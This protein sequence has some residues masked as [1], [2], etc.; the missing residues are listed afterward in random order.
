[1]KKLVQSLFVLLFVA[2]AALAQERTVSGTITA[3]EDGLPLPGVSVT[4]KGGLAGTQTDVNGRYS[5]SVPSG[6]KFLAF[7]FIGFLTKEAAIPANN[8][9]SLSLANDTKQ[10]GEVVVVGA[11]GIPRE[12]KSL[13]YSVSRVKAEAL[14]QKSEPDLLK[15]LQ[16]KVAGVDIRSSQGTPGAATRIQIRGNSSFFG[17]NQPLIVVD[18]VPYSND[19]ITTSSQVSGGGAYSSGIGNLDPNDIASFQ[20]LKGSAAG[21]LYGSRASNGVI[22]ITT[23]SGNGGSK[24]Q[25]VQVNYRSS[26]SVENVSNL[27]DYQNTYGAGAN[28]VYQNSNGTWGPSFSSRDSIP[29]W[30]GYLAKY[31]KLFPSSGNIAYRAVPNNV[32]DLFKTGKVYENS[33]SL[34]GGGESSSI[35][36][37]ASNLDQ[38][39]YVDNSGYKRNSISAG[40]NTSTKF[41]LNLHGNV[42]YSK[43]NQTGGVFGENQVSGAASQFARTLF[44]ARN[45]DI[46]GL[47]YEDNITPNGGGQFDNPIW[48]AYHNTINTLE[49][50]FVTN[51]SADMKVYKWIN[52]TFRI[53]S[54]VQRLNRD[55]IT[56]IGSRAAEGLGR[57]VNANY[58]KQEIESTFL[59]SFNPKISSDFDLTGTLGANNNRRSTSNI[60]NSGNIFKTPNIFRLSNTTQQVFGDNISDRRLYGVLGEATLGYKGYAYVT[61][62]GRN[63]WSSTLPVNNR[64]YFY[65]SVSGSLIFSQ[66]LKLS[67]KVL[68]YGKV[69]AGYAKVGRD[70]DPYSLSNVFILNQPFLSQNTATVSTDANNPELKPEFTK[71]LEIGT[72]LSFFKGRIKTDIAY[73]DKKSS[74]LIAP[75]ATPPSS[76][77]SRYYTNYGGITNKGVEVELS[78]IP[79]RTKN[80]SWEATA[81]FTKNRNTVTSLVEG[82]QRIAI[83]SGLTSIQQFAE[84][85]MPF[86]YLRGTLSSRDATGNLLIDPSTGQL[87]EATESGFVGDPNPDFKAGL[88]NTFKY[89]RFFLNAGFDW[90]QGGSL[91]SVT[92]SSLLGR[93][94]TT[95]TEDRDKTWVI[96]GVYGDPNSKQ[97]VLDGNGKTIPNSVRVTTNDLYFGQTFAIN[98]SSEWNTYDATVYRLRELTLGYQ[99]PKSVFNKFPISNM[100]ISLT[101][102]NLFYYAP[103]FPK[104]SNF[105]PDVN[106]FGSTNTQGIELSAAPSTRRFGVNLSVTF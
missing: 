18:G 37:T 51:L 47:P 85:G 68:D 96:P 20:V 49:E 5:I 52:A 8:K 41:G 21:A 45:W 10:L 104:G 75:I 73:Y 71:E 100:T 16:G 1:M 88:T 3:L 76:G 27:P 24:G 63:D 106:S 69:R 9:L 86:G 34:T 53:G 23:K 50:R 29:A 81:I 14:I 67:D 15:T 12:A 26:A 55:Q 97:A 70:A 66:A 79:V 94:V 99:I 74:N 30:G 65:P 13:G 93:G 22:L 105:D 19:Q 84:V 95:D 35:A 2:G 43:S 83:G 28:Y 62:T 101:G 98:T 48:S 32:K 78:G 7:S 61:V 102:R 92:N 54:N 6:S 103:G 80:F 57:I 11:L 87:I 60:T 91:Y 38:T 46:R 40:G 33:I 31:P 4:I 90:T 82:V 72:N 25:P 89:K 58:R 77:V 42:S 44:L 39:G 56:D 59:L 64:S 17:D 36:I